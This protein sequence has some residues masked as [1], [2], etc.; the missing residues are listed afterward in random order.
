MLEICKTLNDCITIKDFNNNYNAAKILTFSSDLNSEIFFNSTQLWLKEN[1]FSYLPSAF[2][3]NILN[4][5]YL[6]AK[7]IKYINSFKQLSKNWDGYNANEIIPQIINKAIDLLNSIEN[8][9]NIEIFPTPRG[10]I[11]FEYEFNKKY[12]EIEI[13]EQYYSVLQMINN[14]IELEE[15]IENKNRVLEYVKQF[16]NA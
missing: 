8:I 14:A 5:D 3:D 13:F 2:K 11:Q 10:T 4:F 1:F 7:K 16:F 15:E 12:F 6:K 9:S